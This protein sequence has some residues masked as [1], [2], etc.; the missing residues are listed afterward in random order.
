MNGFFHSNGEQFVHYFQLISGYHPFYPSVFCLAHVLLTSEVWALMNIKTG[1]QKKAFYLKLCKSTG[2]VLKRC[3][4]PQ[5]ILYPSMFV[6]SLRPSYV[7]EFGPMAFFGSNATH[8][9]RLKQ[10]H[11]VA[12]KEVFA[13]H[14][15]AEGW[16][17]MQLIWRTQ[18]CPKYHFASGSFQ[19]P[20]PYAIG[21][22]PIPS[23]KARF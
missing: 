21:W 16:L 20:Y 7:V 19:F 22:I 18:F 13:H 9:L 4:S 14:V 8:A 15:V 17:N 23:Y 6:R 11:F 12:K 3:L 1:S 5:H 2:W 10:W